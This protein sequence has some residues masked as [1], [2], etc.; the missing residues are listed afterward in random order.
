[1]RIIG[2]IVPILF[3][4]LVLA[5]QV[6]YGTSV[7]ATTI[8]GAPQAALDAVVLKPGDLL[9][10]EAVRAAIQ[11]LYDFGA[12][13]QI[14]VEWEAAPN[15]TRV[16][17][18]VD[19]PFFFSTIRLEPERLLE[20]P[21][22][23]YVDL[24]Y[25]ERFSRTQLDR[26]VAELDD[27]LVAR[28]Y[29]GAEI[30]TDLA[31]DEGSRLVTVTVAAR[32]GDL[33]RI[34]ELGFDGAQQTYSDEEMLDTFGLRPGDISLRS[35]IQ[36]GRDAIRTRFAA[37]GFLATEVI[38]TDTYSPESN[39]VNLRVT[40]NPGAFIYVAV[41]PDYDLSDEEAFEMFPVFEEEAIDDELIE[42]GRL[43]LLER[44][45]RE[46]YLGA[47][48]TSR[49]IPAPR[50]N[51][52]Q[53]NYTVE[54]GVRYSIREVRIEGNVFFADEILF[55]RI[56]ISPKGLFSRGVF[57]PEL[58]SEAEETIRRLYEASGFADTQVTAPD[59]TRGSGEAADNEIDVVITVDEGR[60]LEIGNIFFEGQ[61]AFAAPDLADF[62]VISSG[63]AYSPNLVQAGRRALTTAYH[64]RGYSEVRV[65]AGVESTDSDRID[66]TYRITEGESSRI[67]RI[68]VSGNTLTRDT[69]VRR[70]SILEEGE[71]FDPESIQEAQSQLYS[72]GLFN[73][74][75]IV[76]LDR[77][78]SSERD[79]LI[80]LED[81]GPVVLTYGVGAQDREGIRGTVELSHSNL[82]G[83]D[84]SISFRVRGSK[85]EQRIQT[86]YREPQLF[87]WDIDG[88]ASLFIE[89]TRQRAFDA[90][91]VDFS[92]QSFKQFANQDSLVM[93]AS[94]QTV[95]LRDVRD[96]PFLD[97][98]P[99][100]E[101]II[102][103]AR[104]STS[105]VRDTRDDIL[106]PTRGNY[107]TGTFQVAS[108]ALGS[109]VNFTN[110]FSQF[111]IYR[112]ANNAVLAAS[113]RLGWIQPFG[114]TDRPPITERYFAGGSTTLRGFGLDEAGVSAG[115]NA[116][117]IL[118]LE[119]RFPIPFPIS[120][121]GGALFYDTGTVFS[122]MSDFT[123][124]DFTHTA[125]FGLRYQTPLGPVRV[126]F[127]FNMNRQPGDANN[128][129]FFT[130]GHTF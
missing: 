80:Q 74:V 70:N 17:F 116:M 16:L 125:G 72:T 15:G 22:S 107:F 83:L 114:G 57:S 73:R 30:S 112:P 82:W 62:V 113:V 23:S 111:S 36:E 54:T 65:E 76:P 96:N 95:N 102:Q 13:G 46:G 5:A 26:I 4:P 99:D 48:V 81:A 61:A 118:N 84:R 14:E 124:G 41:G 92:F 121:L 66:I 123:F 52:F 63:Q 34:G 115:G 6:P 45:R 85:R 67:G 59:P 27:Q 68:F 110:V 89:R 106:N 103:I 12:F 28:G 87:N 3:L 9:T 25:G 37:E 29:I 120:G 69:V 94:Y 122:E 97:D 47:G 24:P 49:L 39:L 129:V 43:A 105:Y 101:G 56:G 117:T 53:I 20:R 44:L 91:R 98:F 90:S 108:T 60:R 42:E 2:L 126:D 93:S 35:D 77:G 119:Y 128:K 64:D 1:M 21:L 8:N 18:S 32:T 86:T 10:P 11:S 79:L 7:T 55:D 100:E 88:F 104:I 71:A 33:V 75:D 31:F 127:G 51:A 78:Q 130:L 109:E 50:D 19:P 40:T 38:V 58:L